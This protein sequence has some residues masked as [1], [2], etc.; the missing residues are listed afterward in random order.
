MVNIRITA[1]VFSLADKDVTLPPNT[2]PPFT[3]FKRS[4]LYI[5]NLPVKIIVTE[6][7]KKVY[8]LVGLDK[9]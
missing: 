9:C 1:F 4:L 8:A 7:M 6:E 3:S 5:S 2:P